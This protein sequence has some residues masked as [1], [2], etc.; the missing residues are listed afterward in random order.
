M[1]DFTDTPVL[2]D[3]GVT[4]FQPPPAEEL[5]V[6]QVV[7]KVEALVPPVERIVSPQV[8]HKNGQ[9]TLTPKVKAEIKK[10]RWR[11]GQEET[12]ETKPTT[13]HHPPRSRATSASPVSLC[14]WRLTRR[15]CGAARPR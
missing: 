7:Q 6:P 11:K 12:E 8:T 9:F 5:T 14:H 3:T 1:I 2:Q 10:L 15:A 4:V 13:L